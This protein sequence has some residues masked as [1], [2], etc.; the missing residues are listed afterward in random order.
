[1]ANEFAYAKKPSSVRVKHDLRRGATR[2]DFTQ[3][4]PRKLHPTRA[5]ETQRR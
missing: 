1:V 5:K 3:E 2:H 4:L